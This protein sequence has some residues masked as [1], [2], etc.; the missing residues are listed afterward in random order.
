M[1]RRLH[2][3]LRKAE[4]ATEK[5]HPR[6]IVRDS[7]VPKLEV[8]I[9]RAGAKAFYA[10]FKPQAA[11]IG[12]LGD[13][14]TGQT[15]PLRIREYHPDTGARRC[16]KESH[17]ISDGAAREAG[18]ARRAEG[19]PRYAVRRGLLFDIYVGLTLLRLGEI[20]A[21]AGTQ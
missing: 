12:K 21:R 6:M 20:I 18:S 13:Q 10:A 15:K 5:D 8:R 9:T 17:R 1:L 2:Y 14:V 3:D 7:K 19:K 4:K 16:P 11:R